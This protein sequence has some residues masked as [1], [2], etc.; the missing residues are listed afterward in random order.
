M[1]KRGPEHN[2]GVLRCVHGPEM[3]LGKKGENWRGCQE[4]RG[5]LRGLG[6]QKRAGG[7]VLWKRGIQ[8]TL[9]GCLGVYTVQKWLW[10]RREKSG[11]VA[12]RLEGV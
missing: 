4:T 11:G 12:S 2:R 8:S 1:E 10:G 9:G 6:A 5:S 3:P 7:P